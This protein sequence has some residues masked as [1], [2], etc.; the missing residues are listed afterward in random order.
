MGIEAI[1]LDVW[2]SSDD[3]V[4]VIHGGFEGQLEEFTNGKGLITQKTYDELRQLNI[5]NSK[6]KIP[7][8]QE[9]L[10]LCKKN[11][12]F[13]NIEI[14]EKR[15]NIGIVEK[16]LELVEKEKMINSIQISSFQL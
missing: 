8:L 14:K 6:E 12:I 5:K 9:V 11:D 7:L 16:V 15:T 1:E 2:L 10:N 13:I 4:V 3:K